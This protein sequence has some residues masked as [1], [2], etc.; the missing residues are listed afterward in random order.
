MTQVPESVGESGTNTT[1]D[2]DT[3]TPTGGSKDYLWIWHSGADGDSTYTDD[4]PTSFNAGRN[5]AAA[6]S[7]NVAIAYTERSFAAASLD[8]ASVSIDIS[9]QWNTILIAIHPASD[10]SLRRRRN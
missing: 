2:V 10:N 6:G 9:E 3:L 4:E 7:S 5:V 1:P 8:P